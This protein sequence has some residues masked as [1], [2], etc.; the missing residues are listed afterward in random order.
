MANDLIIDDRSSGNL[1]SNLGFE[2]RLVTDQVMGGVS[3]G[4]LTLDT[5]RGKIVSVCEVMYQPQIMAVLC[6]WLCRCLMKIDTLPQ[7]LPAL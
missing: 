5:Y 1:K 7:R 3:S 4:Q 6:K 2:W